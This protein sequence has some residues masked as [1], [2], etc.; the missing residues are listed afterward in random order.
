MGMQAAMQLN[1]RVTALKLYQRL[2]KKL[3][4]DLGVAPESQLQLLYNEALK[5]TRTK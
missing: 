1:D 4:H 2:E 3:S 5:R